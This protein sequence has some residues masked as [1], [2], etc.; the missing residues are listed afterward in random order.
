MQETGA[1]SPKPSERLFVEGKSRQSYKPL[2]SLLQSDLFYQR[3][4]NDCVGFD[5]SY[6][7]DPLI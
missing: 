6:V 1:R 7:L 2:N 4:G 3:D 5:E